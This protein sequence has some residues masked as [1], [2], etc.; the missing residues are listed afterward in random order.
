MI[1]VVLPQH[2]RTL[3]RVGEEVAL[4]VDERQVAEAAD[5]GDAYTPEVAAQ[6]ERIAKGIK[7][8]A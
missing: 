8:K 4:E 1:R 7:A 5:F 2:L 3:A 6:E